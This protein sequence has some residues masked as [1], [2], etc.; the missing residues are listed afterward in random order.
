MTRIG[1][2]SDTHGFLDDSILRHFADCDEIWHAGDIGPVSLLN[3]LEETGKTI[4]AVYGNID[5]H[6]VRAIAPLN[7]LF[8][9][10]KKTVLITHIGG[11][12]GR[13]NGRIRA[14]I[15][16]HKP[17]IVVCGHSHILKVIYDKN[18]DHLHINPGACG[19]QGFQRVRTLLRFTIHEDEISDMQVIELG[20]RQEPD[21]PRS[22]Q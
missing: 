21:L 13:Y 7:L 3:T 11:Y 14:L 2:L 18:L 5:D 16:D 19:K 6:Q 8:Q 15:R 4:R 12:P 9:V 17:D 22:D 1:V 10:E 20:K